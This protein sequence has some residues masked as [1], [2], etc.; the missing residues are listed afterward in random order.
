MNGAGYLACARCSSTG[1]L[2][3]IEPVSTISGGNQPLSPPK[4][5]RCSNCSGSGK[6]GHLKFW[7]LYFFLLMLMGLVHADIELLVLP[8]TSMYKAHMHIGKQLI[9]EDMM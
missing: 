7:F 2:V 8:D 1:A 4:T 9:H 3:L 5:E 6:V